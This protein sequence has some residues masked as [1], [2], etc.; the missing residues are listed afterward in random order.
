MK[1][2]LVIGAGEFGKNM[3]M[4]LMG[5]RNEVLVVDIDES[6]INRIAPYVTRA[7]V[8]DCMDRD[9]L[10]QF[11]VRNFDVCFVC[12]SHNFQSSLE[13]TS[14]L[15][16]L[17][18]A[19]VV[20][21]SDSENQSYL[22]K[23]VG[24]DDVIY[25]EKDMAERTAMR[26]SMHGAFDYVELSPEYAIVEVSVPKAWEGHTIRDLDV[27]LKHRVNII[28]L[29][30]GPHI[31]PVINADYVFLDTDRIIISGEK[32]DLSKLLDK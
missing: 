6:K 25:P 11:G 7:Q 4:K 17:G 8:G 22:L 13:I 5:L 26:Y 32:N 31:E 10:M 3:T 21:K 9:V 2:I 28:G 27:R 18:A 23:K 19:H 14:L 16:D 20:A 12:I 15:K 24:A 1:S 29:R 30:N